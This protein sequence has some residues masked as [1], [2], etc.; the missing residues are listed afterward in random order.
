MYFFV[1]SLFKSLRH[2]QSDHPW[3]K[4]FYL[5]ELLQKWVFKI[6]SMKD[7]ELLNQTKPN[8]TKK[9]RL[10]RFKL[11]LNFIRNNNHR[12][13]TMIMLN[14]TEMLRLKRKA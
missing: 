4:L 3:Q 2:K 11:I 13:L 14:R 6:S 7:R 12:T 9:K 5:N 10:K 8:K 1:Y